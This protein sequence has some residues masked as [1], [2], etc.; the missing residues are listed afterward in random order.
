MSLQNQLHA[1]IGTVPFPA[2]VMGKL[3]LRDEYQNI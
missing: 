2:P 3:E 1:Y